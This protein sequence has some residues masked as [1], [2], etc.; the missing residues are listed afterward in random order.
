MVLAAGRGARLGELGLRTPKALVPVG[1]VPL[2]ET[3]L[4]RLSAAGFDEVVVNVHHLADRIESFVAARGGARGFGLR[5]LE[6]SREETLLDTGGGLQR[7][8]PFLAGDEPFLVH[9]VDVLSDLDLAA[10]WRDHAS[11]RALASLWALPRP[12]RRPLLFDRTTGQLVGRVGPDGPQLVR[13][14]IGGSP[15]EPLGFCGIHAVSPALLS[16]LTETPPFGLADAW[17]R[18]ASEGA[19]IR[20]HR[21]DQARWRDCGRPEDLRPL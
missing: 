4:R 10:L 19:S 21:A 16:R 7:A 3:T 12:T 14:T 18:L 5:R 6:F 20:V 11:C 17:L 8:A 1:G 2:L 15:P 9:N 13:P